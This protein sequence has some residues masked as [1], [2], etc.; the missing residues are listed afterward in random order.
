MK[1]CKTCKVEKE[2]EH[3][4][5]NGTTPKGTLK[6]KPDCKV[7]YNKNAQDRKNKVLNEILQ[8]LNLSLECSVC[9]YKRNKA[10]LCFHHVNSEEKDFSFSGTRFMAK[11]TLKA[12]VAKCVIL[13]Q[14]CHMEEHHPHLNTY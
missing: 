7:C 1:K 10:A 8:E 12:E 9:G 13:C 3:F 6:Y 11:E 2:L 14:N 4:P 5:R